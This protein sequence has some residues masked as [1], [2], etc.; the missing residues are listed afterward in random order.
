MGKQITV[1]MSSPLHF[2][3]FPWLGPRAHSSQEDFE[4]V[5]RYLATGESQL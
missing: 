4:P 3:T 1:T 2:L 5:K